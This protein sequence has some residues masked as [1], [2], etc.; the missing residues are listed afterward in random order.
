MRSS[1]SL[2]RRAAAAAPQRA[3]APRSAG[4]I[5]DGERGPGEGGRE[6]ERDRGVR[7]VASMVAL[8]S[9]VLKRHKKEESLLNS[10]KSGR[11]EKACSL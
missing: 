10:Y 9:Y 11:V 3:A 5:W 1:K 7:K 2:I 6:R 4:Y 8:L